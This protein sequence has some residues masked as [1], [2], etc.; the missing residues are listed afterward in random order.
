MPITLPPGAPRP[1]NAVPDSVVTWVH[2][3]GSLMED[4]PIRHSKVN[5]RSSVA[6]RNIIKD[7]LVANDVSPKSILILSPS[8]AQN[9]KH[10]ETLSQLHAEFPDKNYKDI[11]VELLGESQGTVFRT[12]IIDVV[13]TDEA[14]RLKEPNYLTTALDRAG[15]STFIV[16]D[17][18]K[19]RHIPAERSRALIEYFDD[20]ETRIDFRQVVCGDTDDAA[21]RIII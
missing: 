4:D 2:V 18:Q 21:I 13:F 11:T 20:L 8:A 3:Y 10:G 15:C 19:L 9:I 17:T 14:G 1:F 7:L 12:V 16:A 5:A 6:I